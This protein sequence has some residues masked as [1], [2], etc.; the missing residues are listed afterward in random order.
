MCGAIMAAPLAIPATVTPGVPSTG[1]R[2]AA[3][4]GTVSVVIIASTACAPPS[5]VSERPRIAGK[6]FVRSSCTPISPVEATNTS[7][8]R[9]P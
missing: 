4:L 6:S 1:K 7:S 3:V 5:P 9:T 2:A 8:G